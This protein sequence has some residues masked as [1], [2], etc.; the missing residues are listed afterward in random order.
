MTLL[1]TPPEVLLASSLHAHH[2]CAAHSVVAYAAGSQQS[3]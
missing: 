3:N 1:H 2:R